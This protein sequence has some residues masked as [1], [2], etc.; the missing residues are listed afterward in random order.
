M[1]QVC[2][3]WPR[4]PRSAAAGSPA[5]PA[6]GP[7]E[8]LVRDRAPRSLG[9]LH[10]YEPYLRERQNSG[11]ANA[12]TPWQEIR[13]AAA[14]ASAITSRVSAETPS[15]PPGSAVDTVAL[16]TRAAG[17]SAIGRPQDLT[18]GAQSLA[19]IRRP[20]ETLSEAVGGGPSVRNVGASRPV[21]ADTA[22]AAR[23]S[24]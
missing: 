16:E 10:D 8:L 13:A 9:I 2:Q 6:V 1:A 22:A 5:G 23:G 24:S 4:R 7:G 3:D 21:R 19:A 18:R 14:P 15:C 12:T 17:R 20:P 11:C